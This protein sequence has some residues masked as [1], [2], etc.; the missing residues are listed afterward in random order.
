MR[1]VLKITLYILG[2]ILLLII[3]AI[4]ALNTPWGQNFVRGKAEAF[5]NKKLKTEVRIGHLGY[6]LPKFI[7]LNDVL[8][9]DQAKDTLLSVNTL[10]V[11]VA[12]LELLH[13]KLDLQLLVLNGVHSH[14]YRN[15]PDTA[16]NFS[17]IVDAFAGKKKEPKPEAPKKDAD[18]SGSSFEIIVGKVNINDIHARFDDQT[19]GTR[20]AVDLEHLG[21]QM[22]KLDL[23]E[24]RFHVKDLQV[25]GLI[26]RFAQDTSY[27][28][29]KPRTDTGK[30]QLHFVADNVHLERIDFN[31]NDVLNKLLFALNLGT[32]D[33]DLKNFDLAGNTVD[34]NKL[35]IANTKAVLT[36]GKH[37]G[38]PA[39]VDTIVKKD[40]T[41]GWLVKARNL[42]FSGLAFTMDN[43][44]D[45]KAAKGID[46]SH[47]ALKDLALTLNNLSYTSDSISG[48]IQHLA[49]K[50]KS[51][52]DLRELKT[53]FHY[54]QQGATL[55]ELYLLTPHTL[56]KDHAEVHYA[57]VKSLKNNIGAMQLNI[58][59]EKSLVGLEDVLI[60]A[61]QLA[62]QQEIFRK[63]PK[64]MIRL[65]ARL[66]GR[67][68]NMNIARLYVQTLSNTEL[69]VNGH[70]SGLP[71][72]DALRY[73]LHITKLNSSR[74]ELEEFVPDSVLSS[75]RVP[76]RFGISGDVS[77]TIKD[78]NTDLIVMST[79]GNA[80]LK[81]TLAMSPGK[82]RET[83]DMLV[84]TREL[85]LGRI[86]KKDSLLG[87]VSASIK[88]KGSGFDP[89][90]AV[91]AI[92]GSITSAYARG[93]RYHDI[94]FNAE[95]NAGKADLKMRAQDP[96]LRMHMTGKAD[97]TKEKPAIVANIQLDSIDFQALKM[98]KTELRARGTIKADFPVLDADYPKGIFTWTNPIINADGKR[99][100]LDSM[101]IV[102]APNDTN[103][104]NINAY[105]QVVSAHI[106]GK[107]PLTQIGNVIKE[108]IDRQYSA[109]LP[110]TSGV[111]L[112]NQVVGTPLPSATKDTVVAVPANYSLK[113]T[114]SVTDAP[115]LHSIV[116]G[117]TTFDSI[118]IDGSLDPRSML[119]NV[120]IPQVVYGSNTIERAFVKVSGT[121]SAFTYKLTVDKISAGS[122][123]LWY[124]D[125]HG[126]LDKNLITANLSV[127]DSLKKE[128][129]AL[130][131]T[132]QNEGAEQVITLK[133]GLKLDYNTWTVAQPNK[134]VLTNGGY[135]VQNFDI[136]NAG[137]YIRANSDN[138]SPD[139]QLKID[140]SNFRLTNL[141]NVISKK[142]TAL[143]D[144]ILAGKINMLKGPGGDLQMDA[145]IGITNLSVLSDTLGD[146]KALV[147]NKT[148]N[149]LD[150]KVTLTGFG[151]DIA[152]TGNY[153]TTPRN[154]NDFDMQ[155]AVKALALRSFESLA[156]SQI[157]NSSGYIRGD[158]HLTGSPTAPKINGEL[159]TDNLRTTVTTI[160]SPFKFP[161]E[162][163][164]FK[165]D[166]VI[167][168]KFDI[169][170]SPDNKATVDGSISIKELTNPDMDLVIKA[171]NWRAV[172][173]TAKDNKTFYGD[174]YITTNLTVKGTPGAPTV[175]GSLNVLK[176]TNL[177]IVT[178]EKNPEIES[179]KGIVK[180]VNGRDSGR[181]NLL[182]P[183]KK[184]TVAR[185]KLAKGSDI[186]VNVVVDKN[187]Q[188]S[189]VIDQ[190]NGDFLSVRGDATLNTS[191]ARN[192]TIALTG[193][194]ELH[195]GAY[196]FNYNFIKRRF[197]IKDGSVITFAGDPVNG[198]N[199]NITATYQALVPPYDLVQRQVPDQAAL[200]YYKQRIPFDIELYLKGQVLKP[201][202]SFNVALPENKI[203]PLSSDQIELV[204]GKLSQIRTDTSEL[205]KQV[206]AVLIL[207]R[208]VSDDPFHSD[209]SSSLSA[210]ALQSVSTFIGEQLNKA[211]GRFVKGVDLSVD[212]ATTE[213]YTTGDLRQRTDLNVAASKRL[214]NDRLKLTVGNNFEL[215]GPQTTSQQTSYV[216]SNLAADYLLSADGKYT[217]RGY[218]SAYNEGVLQG[219][220]TETGVNFIVSLDYNKFKNV[221]K[222]RDKQT[223]D[224]LRSK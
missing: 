189:L 165:D 176:G 16:F 9:R 179:R 170:D 178:P 7:V 127:A 67:L 108:R 42:D 135:Y 68:D 157:K 107:M 47:L 73:N 162:T 61:P 138:A 173:S 151:N 112:F 100:Y 55:D 33:L 177:T 6:G 145:D 52:V 43:E 131:A 137:Q 27:L 32:L 222:K 91:A 126:N 98:Y 95:A 144:G 24:M 106:T 122:L 2:S 192:G 56:L 140:I 82:G 195:E 104:Q 148:A 205:N 86:L 167:F 38:A 211:A 193:N 40:T 12:M 191:I 214:L 63:Y 188:F 4:A 75:I 120:E 172:H 116:P 10:K 74:A 218:R 133:E 71:N 36:I 118:H 25:A 187:A 72:A 129:F 210:T 30:T 213:D 201:S 49:V 87:V 23:D 69:E 153:Y 18:T 142:D 109:P 169:V 99:Y 96:N 50:E 117:L 184:D 186:N 59:L 15:M 83:Y 185:R 121:D 206:F 119:L 181:L 19:G 77:G 115:M 54:N 114:A 141:T 224:T 5:L 92:N 44:N 124:A 48:N 174:L 29:E 13:H 58:D 198:T 219:Y 78:Y 65:D 164:R 94:T 80:Y 79:D 41:E 156:M 60:F 11:D 76:D 160:N 35:A 212:L 88:A 125:V 102:S 37:A 26:T 22:K 216:P 175:D 204:Q 20:L 223:S 57:S 149:T 1:K 110:D 208:F 51:G 190:A 139:A 97:F 34:I 152:I 180:F 134:I 93:Y 89:K 136:S 146:L 203:Y 101:Y 62:D 14:V 182:I 200:N 113:L 132:M 207:G 155:M 105:L 81:G 46:Y 17:Y 158:L 21:L 154:G 150:A 202:I 128:R 199:M 111:V 168:D 8:I 39:V 221:F 196:Q 159:K 161:S 64:A 143:A 85:N 147:N 53:N 66:N 28:P 217:V 3:I 84:T 70:M 130:A 209:A 45:P 166:L 31:Y 163:I 103:G 123:S 171:K 215:E 194:Y 197:K 183:K 220:V 90:K